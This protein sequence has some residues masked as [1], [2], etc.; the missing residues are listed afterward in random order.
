MRILVLGGDGMLGHKLLAHLSV[1]HDV[2]VTLRRRLEDYAALHLFNR[3]NA[4]PDVEVCSSERLTE[5]LADFRPQVVINAVGVVKQRDEAKAAIPSIQVNALLPH[6]VALLTRA[7]NARL[8]HISTDCVFSGRVG[9]YTEASI[10]DAEDLYGRTKFL[11]E[12]ADV[13]CV[14]LRTSI[15]GRELSRKTGLLEWFLAQRNPIKGYTNAIYSGFTTQ[16][17]ARVIERVLVHFP[18]A[19]GLYHVSSEPISKYA[20]LVMIRDAL[21]KK[22]DIYPDAEFRCDRSMRSDRF[23]EEFSYAAPSW[24]A[25]VEELAQEIKRTGNDL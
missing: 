17:M 11:G 14:T 15:I 4:Y 2:R 21:G 7:T 12:V 13:G 18:H 16:E 1:S 9:G 25:M 19:H 10:A 20:L 24:Q 8:V 23:R 22:I 3:G 5:V 6:R